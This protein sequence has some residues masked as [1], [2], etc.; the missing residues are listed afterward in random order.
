MDQLEAMRAAGQINQA[1][2][3]MA[4]EQAAPGM[5]KAELD[6]MIGAFIE[7]MGGRPAFKGY[8]GFPGNACLSIDEEV[9]HGTPSDREIQE[10]SI[11]T[12]DC[13][14]EVDGWCV[15]AARTAIIGQP[16][17]ESEEK[18]VQS[19]DELLQY[20][21]EKEIRAGLTMFNLAN[22]MQTV[23]QLEGLRVFPQFTGHGIGRSIHED[24]TIFH[25]LEGH[26]KLSRRLIQTWKF[27]AGMTV[28]VEPITTLGSPIT[29][30][31]EDGWTVI[32][33]DGQ[34]SAHF[35]HTLLITEN[36]CEV[37]S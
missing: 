12:V 16:R 5:T 11:L 29:I 34:P 1:A 24:P 10:G 36:G 20:F 18:L 3:K 6:S 7:K 17:N 14:V 27:E 13:G 28:C 33:Q 31:Q 4:L 2:I 26:T 32:S 25:T 8:Q 37:L 15:D 23:A 30:A 22:R 21:V 9:V 35:E 19:T